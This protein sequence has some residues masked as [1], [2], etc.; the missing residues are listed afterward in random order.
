M[1]IVYI[2]AERAKPPA[3]HESIGRLIWSNVPYGRGTRGAASQ[4]ISDAP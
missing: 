3:S 4:G 1:Y 2:V